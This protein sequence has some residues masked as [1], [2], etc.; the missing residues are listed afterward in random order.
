MNRLKA[1]LLIVPLC[2][3]CISKEAVTERLDNLEQRIAALEGTVLAVNSNLVA[4]KALVSEGAGIIAY[5]VIPGG[6]TVELSDGNVVTIFLG[7]DNPGITPIVGL[8]S[9]GHWVMSLDGINFEPIEGAAGMADADG[10]TPIFAVDSN[11]FWTISWDGETWIQLLQDGKPV[12]AVDGSAL[13]S[14]PSFFTA[15]TPGENSVTFVLATG[16]ELVVPLC[17]S[18]PAVVLQGY[19][20]DEVICLDETRKYIIETE[21]VAQIAL[22]VPEG[23]SASVDGFFT[24]TAPSSGVAGIVQ[25]VFWLT[26]PEG[27]L[28]RQ[29]FSFSLNPVHLDATA[30]KPWNDFVA[31]NSENLLLDY[32]YAGYDHGETAPADVSTLGYT[33]YNIKDYMTGSVSARDAFLKAATAALGTPDQSTGNI[34]FPPKDRANAIIYFPEGEYDLHPS[35]DEGE[36]ASPC[37][38]IRAGN[39]ILKGDGSEKSII[40]MSAPMQPSDPSVLYSSPDLIQIK[41]YSA[42]SSYSVPATVTEDAPKASFTV[43]VASASGIAAGDWVCLHMKNNSPEVVAAEVQPYEVNSSWDISVNGVEVIDY[44]QVKSVSGTQVTFVEPLMR[45]V[46]A[47]EGWELMKYPHYENVGVEDLCFRGSAKAGFVHHGDWDYDGGYKPLS[48]SRV[49]NSWVRR[50]CFES[51]SECCSIIYSSNVSAYSILMKGNRGHSA[52]RS[53]ASSR[54]LIAMT[55]DISGEGQGNFHGVGVSKQSMGTVLWRNVWGSD[56]C[57][58]SHSTQPRATLIDCCTG[59]WL[60]GHQGGESVYAPNHLSDL[61]IWNFAAVKADETSFIW[62]GEDWW[63]FMPPVVVGFTGASVDFQQAALVD[64]NGTTANPESLYEA[65]L[66]LRL[67]AVPAWLNSLKY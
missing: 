31:G 29:A 20:A 22:S 8:D 27:L 19:K 42:P 54:V 56:S 43:K 57:F 65:Q 28:H 24:V 25:I 40:K 18:V 49:A 67:G 58:E 2:L 39:F 64:C 44:H 32:S 50:V 41:H 34:V 16:E 1:Y 48:L 63:K 23:W 38:I 15:V 59:A 21:N 61:T 14:H 17:T 5:Q 36:G 12:S 55:A 9:E 35:S 7:A 47:S 4:I 3:C 52:V 6:F 45:S 33:V 26:S 13:T 11:G 46:K 60:R 53:Q 51:T 66:R 62:W 10:A 37:I 30:C